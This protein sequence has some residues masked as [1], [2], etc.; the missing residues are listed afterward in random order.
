MQHIFIAWPRIT[1]SGQVDVLFAVTRTTEK[2]QVTYTDSIK[3]YIE[4]IWVF[5][6]SVKDRNLFYREDTIGNIFT[7]GAATRENITVGVHE[8]FH[9]KKKTNILFISCF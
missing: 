3:G 1:K 5:F 7:S 8:I 4:D 6:F 2:R 9:R